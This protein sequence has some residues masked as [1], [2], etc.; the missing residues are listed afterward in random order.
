MNFNVKHTLILYFILSI[1]EEG[2][3]TV[4]TSLYYLKK[5]SLAIKTYDKLKILIKPI[6]RLTLVATSSIISNGNIV[7][8]NSREIKENV[9][10][11]LK[12]TL[13]KVT[14]AVTKL[15]FFNVEHQQQG[16]SEM[17]V[18]EYCH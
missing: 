11:H 8:D 9:T 1:S 12:D 16:Q 4:K 5:I 7:K 2:I 6:I 17:L 15:G 3:L 10:Y 14:T 13:K 18:R